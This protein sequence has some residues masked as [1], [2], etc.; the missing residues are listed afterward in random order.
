MPVT[1]GAGR[2]AAVVGLEAAGAQQL[3]QVGV[4]AEALLFLEQQPFC[5][6]IDCFTSQPNTDVPDYHPSVLTNTSKTCVAQ[7]FMDSCP[8]GDAAAAV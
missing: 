3:A 1:P 2:I 4:A 7:S 6:D 5:N 8:A